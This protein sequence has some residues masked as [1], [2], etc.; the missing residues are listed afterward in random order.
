MKTETSGD[1]NPKSEGEM[2]HSSMPVDELVEQQSESRLDRVETARAFMAAML[3]NVGFVAQGRPDP[4][5]LASDAF[6]YADAL[7]S[8]AREDL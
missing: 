1:C 4:K 6:E 3:A 5:K 2:P 7:E 8:A